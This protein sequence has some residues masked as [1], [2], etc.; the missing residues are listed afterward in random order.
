MEENKETQQVQEKP[1]KLGI[2]GSYGII[3]LATNKHNGKIYIGQSTAVNPR[4]RWNQHVS[5]S[6]GNDPKDLYYFGRSLKKHGPKNFTYEIIHGCVSQKDLNYWEI[7][8]IETLDCLNSDVGYNLR[9]GGSRG[10]HTEATKQKLREANLGKVLTEEHKRNL[11][12]A[13]IGL[14]H[15]DEWKAKMSARLLGRPLPEEHRQAISDGKT[16]VKFSEEHKKNISIS[17]SGENSPFAKLNWEIVKQIRKEYLEGNT[18]LEKLEEKYNITYMGGIIDNENWCDPEYDPA[19]AQ[20]IKARNKK[21]DGARNS[22]A[23]ISQETCDEIRL[24]IKENPDVID[25]IIGDMFDI[26]TVNVSLIRRNRTWYDPNWEP[27]ERI[28]KVKMIEPELT[29]VELEVQKQITYENRKNAHSAENSSR[30]KFTWEQI[31]TIRAEFGSDTI[32]AVQLAKKYNVTAANIRSIVYNDSWIDINYDT[33]KAFE[34]R[35]RKKSGSGLRNRPDNMEIVKSIRESLTNDPSI[36][37][38]Y[39][40]EKYDLTPQSIAEIRRNQTWH[41]PNYIAIEK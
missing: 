3:Y 4:H 22:Q 32:T 36:P 33:T 5:S 30:A 2:F 34:I 13:H 10:G 21:P 23:K 24:F 41:D 6:L 12:L 9:P 19:P 1:K 38:T 35:A 27:V 17:K 15:S 40:A 8:Y 26:S 20:L 11:S 29:E 7:Y 28:Q 31:N 37:D 14:K 39:F 16:G 25:R 18:S